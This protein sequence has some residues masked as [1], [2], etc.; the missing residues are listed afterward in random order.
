MGKW[1]EGRRQELIWW[2]TASSSSPAE[3]VNG[4]PVYTELGRGEG[5]YQDVLVLDC[6][7]VDGL[8][9]MCMLVEVVFVFVL[10]CI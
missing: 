8:R 4:W 9:Y 7:A 2:H 1:Y 5:M 6:I 10:Y 3:S